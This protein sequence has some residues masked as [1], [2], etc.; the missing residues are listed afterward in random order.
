MFNLN[1]LDL[2]SYLLYDIILYKT[3]FMQELQGLTEIETDYHYRRV[4]RF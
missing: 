4:S 1:I 2:L 3:N